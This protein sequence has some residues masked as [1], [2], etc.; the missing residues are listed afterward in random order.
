MQAYDVLYSPR[1]ID[2]RHDQLTL[3]PSADGSP[4]GARPTEAAYWRGSQTSRDQSRETQRRLGQYMTPAP[5][6]RFMARGMVE[7]RTWGN[8]TL[9]ILDPAA[10]SGVLAAAV[11]EA[12]LALEQRPHR[13]ELLLCE[14]D[15]RMQPLLAECISDL[16][17]L[18]A[19]RDLEL[20]A[21]VE[22]G[23]FLLSP[24]ALAHEAVVDVV[25]ANPPYFKLARRD[26]RCLAHPQAVHGQPNIYALFMAVCARLL[27]AGGVFGFITPRSWTNGLYFRAART[28]LRASLCI[29]G[30]HL[31]DS[32]QA[33]FESDSV[34]QEALITWGTAGRAQGDVRFSSSHGAHDLERTRTFLHPA[35]AVLGRETA[36]PVVLPADDAA[37]PGLSRWRLR[38]TDLGLKVV[39]G[40][41]VGFRA[42]RHVRCS[43]ARNTVP[44]LWMQHVRR[45]SVTW[46]RGHRAENIEHNAESAWMLLPNE[47]CVLL[48]RFSPKEDVRRVCAAAYIG[49]LPGAV[50]GYENH[51]NVI[52][53]G[54]LPL[55]PA[56]ALGLAAY[57]NS[58][59][60]DAYLRQ[61]LGSTQI[62]AIELRELPLPDLAT[63]QTLGQSLPDALTLD[64]V[65]AAVAAACDP[66]ATPRAQAA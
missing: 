15:T 40:P 27:R 50:I 22:G 12:V 14:I 57:L 5:I 37:H 43:S 2:N 56:A 44:L 8:G 7:G 41:V 21:R 29:D 48:R 30:L 17:A 39:T 62:N 34:L 16:H 63:L 46:P 47:P 18:C 1:V 26:A 42:A 49:D 55:S 61:R 60:V 13:I 23:D 24:I 4:V 19:S 20:D 10:G 45:M 11:V 65:D 51:L 6:A 66:L 25:I 31:F 33:H 54:E 32:R 52:R 35:A 53:G 64:D 59:V 28:Q 3:W 58:S 9:R 36:S 38:L